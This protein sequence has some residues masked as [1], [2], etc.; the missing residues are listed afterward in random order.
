MIKAK[1]ESHKVKGEGGFL[2]VPHFQT[3]VAKC[4]QQTRTCSPCALGF[5]KTIN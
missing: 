3:T 2:P 4:L 1:D 5:I